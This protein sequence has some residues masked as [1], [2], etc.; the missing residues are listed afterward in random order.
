MF[1]KNIH[2]DNQDV[3]N[4]QRNIFSQNCLATLFNGYP[5]LPYSNSAIDYHSLHI[6]VNDIVINGRESIIEFG[7]G[8]STIIFG[9]LC[10]INKLNAKLYSIDDNEGWYTIMKDKIKDENLEDY[11]T[12]IYAPLTD[13]TIN[14]PSAHSLKWYNTQI[15]NRELGDKTFDMALTDGPMAYLKEIERSRY[16]ALPYLKDRLRENYSIFLHDSNREGEISIIKDW[17]KVLDTANIRF[18]EKLAGFI[19]GRKYTITV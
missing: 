5:Y 17:Q 9:R 10:K 11:I 6:L 1:D 14:L 4:I 15:L 12:L 18:T 19:V 2:I 16:P 13:V 7:S 8:I 3:L